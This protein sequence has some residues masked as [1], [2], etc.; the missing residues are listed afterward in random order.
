[1]RWIAKICQIGYIRWNSYK[2]LLVSLDPL[3][4]LQG[5]NDSSIGTGKLDDVQFTNSN[6]EGVYEL[7]SLGDLFYMLRRDLF[8]LG[9]CVIVVLL[10]K[11]YV[12]KKPADVADKKLD[13]LHKFFI[14]FIGASIV[15]VL[16]ILFKFFS[17]IFA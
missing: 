5:A 4:I 17:S 14:I 12:T 1:M 2:A 8:Y 6:G 15:A 13:I 7:L 9:A 16:N 10:L 3:K 11:M